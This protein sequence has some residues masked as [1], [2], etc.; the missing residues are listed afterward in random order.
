M[1]MLNVKSF[2]AVG[3]CNPSSIVVVYFWLNIL[4]VM[5]ISNKLV[6]DGACVFGLDQIGLEKGGLDLGHWNPGISIIGSFIFNYS[7]IKERFLTFLLFFGVT[8]WIISYPTIHQS[9]YS[10]R[11]LKYFS[12]SKTGALHKMGKF[13]QTFYLW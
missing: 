3:T 5:I 2:W 1:E 11:Y 12:S 9:S 13:W 6:A 8:L 4:N 10:D 7:T